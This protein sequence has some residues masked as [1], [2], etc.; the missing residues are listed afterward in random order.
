MFDKPHRDAIDSLTDVDHFTVI[1][2]ETTGLDPTRDRVIQIAAVQL[3]F[4]G[5]L[6]KS[7]ATVVK[8]EAPEEYEH[9]AEHVH[10][11]SASDVA[12]GMPLREAMST[13][14]ANLR[15]SILVGHNARFDLAFLRAESARVGVALPLETHLDT[16]LLARNLDVENRHSHRLGDLCEHYGIP[17]GMAHDALEDAT[18]TARLL[19]K[20]LPQW[21]AVTLDGVRPLLRIS[22]SQVRSPVTSPVRSPVTDQ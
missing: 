13:L 2:V 10:G 7:F 6:R 8:P 11:I 19:M 22:S 1:D 3:G 20:L 4:D 21:G 17:F 9:G 14:H 5:D 15:S 18:A 12:R 16:L